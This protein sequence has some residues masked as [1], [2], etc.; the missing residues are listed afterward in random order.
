MLSICYFQIHQFKIYAADIARATRASAISKIEVAESLAIVLTSYA[1]DRDKVFPFVTLPDFET[2]VSKARN[3]SDSDSIGWVPLVDEAQRTEWEKYAAEKAPEW[4]RLSMN[5]TGQTNVPTYEIAPTIHD[6]MGNRIMVPDRSVSDALKGKYAVFWYVIALLVG[7]FFLFSNILFIFRPNIAN[8]IFYFCLYRQGSPVSPIN[9]QFVNADLMREVELSPVISLAVETQTPTISR[10]LQPNEIMID[11]L[12]NSVLAI[13]VLSDFTDNSYA[14]GVVVVYVPWQRYFAG[15]LPRGVKAIDAVLDDSCGR[16]Y[17]FRIVGPNSTQLGSGDLHNPAFNHMEKTWTLGKMAPT[18]G[19]EIHVVDQCVYQLSIYPTQSMMDAYTSKSPVYYAVAVAIIFV[20][21]AGVFLVYDWAVQ[22]RQNKVLKTATRTQAIVSSLFPKNVQERIFKDVEEEVKNDENKGKNGNRFRGNRTKDQ[23]RN[24]L[25][26]GNQ[27]P[28][29]AK[30][31]SLKSKPIADLFPEATVIFADLVGFTAW[32]STREPTQVFTLLENIYHSF[33]EIAKRRRIFKVETVGDCY[34]AVS[35]LPE[36]RKDHAV[37][38]AR[39]SKDILHKFR[40]MVKQMVVEL[41]PDTEDLQLRV[42]LH[43]G[44]V[45]AG[46][47]RGERARFQLFG[48]TMNTT[49]VRDLFYF[50]LGRLFLCCMSLIAYTL[51]LS[52]NFSA[53]GKHGTT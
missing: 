17:T 35:G 2:R 16:Q 20:F 14:V 51:S 40:E 27:Q 47:L 38:M 46:V 1:S 53:Y 30:H 44:P 13:P 11:Q 49:A 43:S 18:E 6:G 50:D 8:I 28:D 26:D 52:D 22:L 15:L 5:V 21:T 31:S 12:A 4:V 3:L 19:A 41:G 36:P 7:S 42:G 34:V 39:F 48:D 23:L 45:T 33:D 9:T 29:V 37:A 25:D 32:S 24:F 10:L